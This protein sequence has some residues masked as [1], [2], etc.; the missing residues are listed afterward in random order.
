MAPLRRVALRRILFALLTALT[1]P[2]LGAEPGAG[3][4]IVVVAG[5]ASPIESLSAQQAAQLYL[6]RVQ[7]L[8]DGTPVTLA[9]LPA[10][11]LRDRFYEQL[12]GRNPAQIR[13]YW[14]RMVFTG[15]AL[16][17]TEVANVDEL[18]TRLASDPQL[19]GYMPA[20]IAGN[21]VRVLLR[22][23]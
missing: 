2:P 20:K 22:L 4:E 16:P 9:D 21:D 3:P 11:A 23:Q 10:G 12:T 15:R 5:P 6:G 19:I 18:R 8:A 7:H 17:P 1:I 13:A 14:S